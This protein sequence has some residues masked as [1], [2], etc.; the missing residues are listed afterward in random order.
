MKEYL[1]TVRNESFEN[2]KPLVLSFT[3]SGCETDFKLVKEAI[4]FRYPAP[5]FK[6]CIQEK[7]VLFKTVT[8]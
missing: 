1:I 4:A 2:C 7:T 5:N 6:L 3:F 8:E